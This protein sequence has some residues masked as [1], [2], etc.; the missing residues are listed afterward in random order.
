M[1]ILA[2]AGQMEMALAAIMA[3]ADA[4]YLAGPH[5]GARAYA[6]N[7]TVEELEHLILYA[8]RKGVKLYLA[9]NTLIKEKELPGAL[10]FAR[11]MGEIGVDALIVQDFGLMHLMRKFAPEVPIHVSTQAS[12]MNGMGAKWAEKSG[13]SRIVLARELS[14]REVESIR[15]NTDIELEVFAHGSLCVSVSGHCLMSSAIGGRSANRGRCAGPCRKVY[16][17][18]EQDGHVVYTG[19][20]LDINDLSTIDDIHELERA[21]VDSIKIEGRMKRPEYVYEAV[22]AYRA[23][24]EG[25]TRENNLDKVS[26]RGFTKGF[27]FDAFGEEFHHEKAP[28]VIGVAEREGEITFTERVEPGDVLELT[29]TRDRKYP[30]TIEHIFEPGEKLK[31]RRFHDLRKGEVVRVFAAST[32][33]TPDVLY[34]PKDV[35]MRFIAHIGERATLDLYIEDKIYSVESEVVCERAERA[36]MTKQRVREQLA[37]VG[38]AYT[39]VA[40]EITVD[41][42]AYLPVKIVN[43]MRRQALAAYERDLIGARTLPEI[44]CE[45]PTYQKEHSGAS[46][47]YRGVDSIGT[48][49]ADT[50]YLTELE[51]IDKQTLTEPV[52]YAPGPVFEEKMVEVRS[53]IERYRAHIEGV[54]ADDVGLV[55]L[56]RELHVPYIAGA[57]LRIA[58]H[59]AAESFADAVRIIPSQELTREELSDLD[60]HTDLP[61]EVYSYGRLPLMRMRYCPYARVKRCVDTRGCANCRYRRGYMKDAHGMRMLF[62]ASP[63]DYRIYSE[64]MDIRSEIPYR[65]LIDL[66]CETDASVREKITYRGELDRGIE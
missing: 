7:F 55:E 43:R 42:G 35:R 34:D 47:H 57:G 54:V 61:I 5:Y 56:A 22:S 26:R 13:C 59:A 20:A 65:K 50:Y 41:E 36:V 66:S 8:H 3:G 1:E 37:K 25:K 4:L 30:F 15:K 16:T 39:F 2:P 52:Y 53:Q 24:L 18:M 10:L 27:L 48:Y 63:G 40:A 58:N 46:V 11:K 23:R 45:A 38:E 62:L 21:G 28:D 51:G 19:Y 29:S 60:C 44:P 64:L 32:R 17:L 12:V 33:V 9:I 14:L 31:D 49:K 6:D